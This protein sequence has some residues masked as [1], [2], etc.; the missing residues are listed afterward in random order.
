LTRYALP[1]PF[2]RFSRYFGPFW[3]IPGYGSL[4]DSQHRIF[5]D[6]VLRARKGVPQPF[7]VILREAS[8]A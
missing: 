3:P 4:A 2:F 5:T 8:R 6:H 1:L 7:A